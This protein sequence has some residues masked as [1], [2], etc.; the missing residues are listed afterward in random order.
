MSWNNYGYYG[1]HIDHIIP[2]SWWQ[3][4]SPEDREFKQCWA[5]CNL[6][7]LWRKDNQIKSDKM[8]MMQ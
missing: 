1:W 7:P 2:V 6:Q 3:F 5:L 4:N 8:E